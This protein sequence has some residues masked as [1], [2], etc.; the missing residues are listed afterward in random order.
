[1]RVGRVWMTCF[2]KGAGGSVRLTNAALEKTE[3]SSNVE[4]TVQPQISTD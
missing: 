2:G 1:M 4:A 3:E